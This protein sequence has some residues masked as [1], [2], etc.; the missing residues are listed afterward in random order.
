MYASLSDYFKFNTTTDVLFN[1]IHN[2]SI[3]EKFKDLPSVTF[4][5]FANV[6]YKNSIERLTRQAKELPF[7]NIVIYN[8]HDLK[9]WMNSGIDMEHLLK[10]IIVDM[11][12]GFG[13]RI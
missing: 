9:K 3:K 6:N 13:N 1:T 8:E 11:V 10:I 7:D 12:I 4:L 2:I 5:S